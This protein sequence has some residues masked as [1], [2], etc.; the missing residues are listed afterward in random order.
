[1]KKIKITDSLSFPEDNKATTS[2]FVIG[3]VGLIA[4]AIGYFVNREQ[5]YFS[6]LT[7]FAFIASLTL[8]SLMYVMLQHL[9]HSSYSVVFRRVPEVIAKNIIYI[10]ILFIPIFFGMHYLFEWTHWTPQ[11]IAASKVLPYKAPFLNY[12][13]YIIRYF[14]YFGIWSFF[15]YRMYKISIKMDETGDWGLQTLL[16]RT[17][18]PGLFL[19]A[20]TVAFASFDWLMELD[21]HW[22]STIFGIYFFAM[23]FQAFFAMLILIL[24]YMR[25][26]GILAN[27]ITDK[28]FSDLGLLLFGFTV[29]YAYIAFAQFLLIYYANIPEEVV[30]FNAHLRGS[31]IY[32]GWAIV[33]GRFAIPFVVLIGQEAKKSLTVLKYVSIL[34][35][36]MQFIELYW[37]VMPNFHKTGIHVSWIDFATIIGL[38]CLFLGLFFNT[39]KKHCMIPKNDPLLADSL[40]K[41]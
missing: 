13:F 41:H 32:I 11:E 1:M 22:Y 34:V 7:S 31:Y 14:I 2:L 4:S 26:K 15:G 25:K 10:A 17:S 28:H 18:G 36:F 33:I 9:T 23:S 8:A 40:N 38:G 5:F 12:K 6:Y 35:I 37:L 20:I 27:T 19:F 3:A 16:R 29:F 30:W 24:L 39:F 21:P